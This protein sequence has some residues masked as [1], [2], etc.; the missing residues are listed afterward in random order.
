MIFLV[1]LHFTNIL[2][3]NKEKK[4]TT[5]LRLQILFKF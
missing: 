1:Q 5:T 2:S 3:T 4:K